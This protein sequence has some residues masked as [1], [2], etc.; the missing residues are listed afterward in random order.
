MYIG[1]LAVA[2][3]LAFFLY[4]KY[5]IAPEINLEQLSLAD[6]SGREVD[7]ASYAGKKVV[8]CFGASWCPNCIEELN[9]LKSLNNGELD[10]VEILVISDEPVEK[11]MAFRE[12]RS[13][14]F[15]FLK[16]NTP[17]SSI[18]INSIPT[19]YLINSH[20]QIKKETVG[21]LNWKDTSTRQHL[22]KLMD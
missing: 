6:L 14:P 11:I 4:K 3:L 12:K 7:L 10:G 22:L 8:L 15:T 1:G 20:F 17:F 18:G 13:Y 9:D 5:K 21:Y 2:A 19:S 16:L